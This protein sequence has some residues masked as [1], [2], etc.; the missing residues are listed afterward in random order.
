MVSAGFVQNRNDGQNIIPDYFE[1]FERR[2]VKLD[3]F[4]DLKE[5]FCMFK[6]DGDQDR[7]SIMQN[8]EG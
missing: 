6:G 3:F 2:N 1:P 5:P 8:E 7:P 4:T